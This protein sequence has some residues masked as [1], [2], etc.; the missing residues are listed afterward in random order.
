MSPGPGPT[1]LSA[2]PASLSVLVET[3]GRGMAGG[4]KELLILAQSTPPVMAGGVRGW[5]LS[6]GQDLRL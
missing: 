2:D 4:V 1:P 6:P 3:G 5:T